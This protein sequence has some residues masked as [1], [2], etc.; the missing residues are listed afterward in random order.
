MLERRNLLFST[1]ILPISA[2]TVALPL[3]LTEF[4]PDFY[5]VLISA[6]VVFTFVEIIP[7]TVCTGPSQI[8]IASSLV[9]IIKLIIFFE[10]PIAFPVSILIDHFL[11]ERKKDR[12]QNDDLKNMIELLWQSA[13]AEVEESVKQHE[14][15]KLRRRLINGAI[16]L[17]TSTAENAMKPY[18]DVVAVSINETLTEGFVRKLKEDAYSRYPVYKTDKHHVVGILIVKKLLGI[19]NFG[20]TLEDLRTKLRRPLVVPPN[21]P[22][23]DLLVEFRKGKSHIALVTEQTAELQRYFISESG[24]E[25][26]AANSSICSASADDLDFMPITIR[27]IVTLEDVVEK[28]LG[29]Y[30]ITFIIFR[31]LS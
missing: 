17:R 13:H 7:Q 24:E 21:K 19:N 5:A 8:R 22:L 10:S 18:D 29:G 26:K 20:I 4:V 15:V 23:L 30:D 16:D 3:L 25:C 14:G 12:Y 1:L 9:P 2:S 6:F 31:N 28:A 27:G 11:G